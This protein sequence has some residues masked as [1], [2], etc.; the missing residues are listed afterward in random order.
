MCRVTVLNES[1]VLSNT[2]FVLMMINDDDDDD[3]DGYEDFV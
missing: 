2:S 3:D 1:L